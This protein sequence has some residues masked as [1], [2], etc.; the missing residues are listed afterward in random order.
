MKPEN[1][2]MY[3]VL[4]GCYT[5]EMLTYIETVGD[6]H[7]FLSTPKMVRREVPVESFDF[8]IKHDIIDFIEVL[9][10]DVYGVILHQYN[11]SPLTYEQESKMADRDQSRYERRRLQHRGK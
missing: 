5:G 3:G 10:D 11:T 1:K 2:G 8:G 7:C 4:R 6:K 9:P